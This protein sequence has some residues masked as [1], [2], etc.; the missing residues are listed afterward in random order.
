M[1]K[2]I[3][4]DQRERL[5]KRELSNAGK[6][7]SKTNRMGNNNGLNFTH[8]H[9]IHS[10]STGKPKEEQII[11]TCEICSKDFVK[12]CDLNKHRYLHEDRKE[13]TCQTCNRMFQTKRTLQ[14]VSTPETGNRI[15][16]TNN[17]QMFHYVYD[18]RYHVKRYHDVQMSR[19][20]PRFLHTLAFPH[21][22]ELPSYEFR[23]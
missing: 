11:Y 18:C 3:T 6:C 15:F 9:Y 20:A 7:Q 10:K 17:I 21:T 19:L 14:W 22:L 8:S 12:L 5:Q 2:N 1:R 4:K 23:E 13:F 16:S